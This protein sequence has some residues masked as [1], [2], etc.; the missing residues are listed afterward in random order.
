M[1][2]GDSP[3]QPHSSG[4]PIKRQPHYHRRNAPEFDRHALAAQ[5][6]MPDLFAQRNKKK[7]ST[8]DSQSPQKENR[9]LRAKKQRGSVLEKFMSKHDP[10]KLKNPL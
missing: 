5:R 2:I 6:T 8:L 9:P 1:I 7:L 4:S 3:D 10:S